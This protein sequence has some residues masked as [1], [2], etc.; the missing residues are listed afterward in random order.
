M[1]PGAMLHGRKS[2]N[3]RITFIAI[4]VTMLA[5]FAGGGW[6]SQRRFLFFRTFTDRFE[7]VPR[8]ISW[9]ILLRLRVCSFSFRKILF[10]F[11]II[12]N[13]C[14]VQNVYDC[15]IHVMYT[16]IQCIRNKIYTIYIIHIYNTINNNTTIANNNIYKY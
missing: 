11:C 15:A 8:E 16:I 13:F 9:R 14:K 1:P 7:N 4:L 5:R 2:P 3:N 6:Y 10:L 12:I